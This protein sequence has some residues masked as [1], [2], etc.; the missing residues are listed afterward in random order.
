MLKYSKSSQNLAV[1]C[2]ALA[3]FC[4]VDVT[5]EL[6]GQSQRLSLLRGG[7]LAIKCLAIHPTITEGG[8]TLLGSGSICSYL[9]K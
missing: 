5:S 9:V 8:D 6:C 7:V 2:L 3:D 4:N 1:K